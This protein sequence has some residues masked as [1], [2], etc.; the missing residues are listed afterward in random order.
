[1]SAT[2]EELIKEMEETYRQVDVELKLYSS[3]ANANDPS[4]Y[5]H[6]VKADELSAK[7]R[8]ITSRILD[9]KVG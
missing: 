8:E 3:K 6:R 1:M 7:A 4:A 9:A 2:R 5:Q